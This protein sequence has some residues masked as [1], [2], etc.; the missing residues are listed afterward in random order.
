MVRIANMNL[1]CNIPHTTMG[2]EQYGI[3]RSINVLPDEPNT[4][5]YSQIIRGVLEAL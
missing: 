2:T 5:D 1:L 4:Y 3:L